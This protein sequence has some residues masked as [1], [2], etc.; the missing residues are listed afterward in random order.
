MKSKRTTVTKANDLITASYAL[1]VREQR[2]ILAAISLI[3]SRKEMPSEIIVTADYYASIFHSKNP[4]RDMRMAAD[5]LWDRE[6]TMQNEI[7]S[8][9]IRWLSEKWESNS[10]G[11]G[12]G[13]VRI[14]FTPALAKYLSALKVR[15]SS[16]DIE[17]VGSLT[18]IY[19]FRLFEMLIQFKAT[20]YLKIS[21]EEFKKRLALS[22]V[23]NKI[24]TL[25][26][27]I[28]DTAIE[29]INAT[30]G[31]NVR[32]EVVLLG[33]KAEYLEFKFQDAVKARRIGADVQEEQGVDVRNEASGQG[34]DAPIE[35]LASQDTS[36]TNQ[37]ELFPGGADVSAD[38]TTVNRDKAMEAYKANI[39]QINTLMGRILVGRPKEDE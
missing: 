28:I 30:T 1:S 36:P 38:E 12:S 39:G 20:G 8:G 35:D 10:A 27:R 17:R 16:Y 37:T 13:H 22:S 21:I 18:T 3:D 32:Y 33:R 26:N 15:F 5:S 14:V 23:Y 6:I 4:Y 19:S 34:G 9:A 7:E 2:L 11:I 31:M 24:S 29:E 25:R